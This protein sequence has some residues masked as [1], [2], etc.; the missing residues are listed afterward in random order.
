[1]LQELLTALQKSMSESTSSYGAN[2]T[3]SSSS[4]SS[5]SLVLNYT[6]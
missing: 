1:L 5:T 3:T 2:G 4:A 6:T